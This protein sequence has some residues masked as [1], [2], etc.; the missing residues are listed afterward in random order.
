[1]RIAPES[2]E[3]SASDYGSEMTGDDR[4]MP[5]DRSDNDAALMME[6]NAGMKLL[7]GGVK[8]EPRGALVVHDGVDDHH[9]EY[10]DDDG[11]QLYTDES[12]SDEDGDDRT[13]FRRIRGY[14]KD[15]DGG[16]GGDD[17]DESRVLMEGDND[18]TSGLSA[19]SKAQ[20]AK[21]NQTRAA[22]GGGIQDSHAA[23]NVSGM[24]MLESIQNKEDPNDPVSSAHESTNKRTK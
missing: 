8:D 15:E 24:L 23:N 6:E 20:L 7:F 17:D 3:G 21:L 16:G 13:S 12:S 9:D 4:S 10:D 1:M 2:S 11:V 14:T 5:D 22:Q 19:S 18:P